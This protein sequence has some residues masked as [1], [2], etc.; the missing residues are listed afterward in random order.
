MSKPRVFV[1]YTTRDQTVSEALLVFVESWLAGVSRPFVHQPT[2]RKGRFEQTRVI[3][4]L[5]RSH[6]LLVLESPSVD[7]SPWMRLELIIGRLKMMPIVRL[8]VEDVRKIGIRT[9]G[10][11]LTDGS[12][13]ILLT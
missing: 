9:R 7:E 3:R 4:A 13:G 6:I 5:L 12:Q 2:R 11:S 10:G 8:R 1:S